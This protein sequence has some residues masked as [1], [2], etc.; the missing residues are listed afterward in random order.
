[1]SNILDIK[2]LTKYYG[3]ERVL[4]N[5]NFTISKGSIV[6]LLGPN[7]SGK[8]TLIKVIANL[9]SS[10][11]GDIS[12]NQHKPGYVANEFISYLPDKNHIPT[13]LTAY[14]S[15]NFFNDFYK[16]FNKQK[17][18]DMLNSMELPLHKK[19]KHLSRGQ[20][21]KVSLALTMSRAAKLYI[22]DEPI[23]AVDPASR[24]F[25]INTIINN[26]DKESSII[27][28]THIISEVEPLLDSFL[29]LKKGEIIMQGDADKTREDNK[30][31]LDQLFREV[32]KHAN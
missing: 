6:G 19:L 14:N 8:T 16:D 15:V 22:L 18:I 29:F 27:I 12:I 7:G 32:F 23:G 13:W 9:L 20:Q 28:S 3:K 26:Y 11:E 21:E 30:K 1:M 10:Y 31:S 17:A 2:N 5:I 4:A 24:D 25:I